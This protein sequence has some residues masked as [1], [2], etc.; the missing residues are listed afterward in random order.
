VRGTP[1]QDTTVGMSKA[2]LYQVS[3][4]GMFRRK[5]A[6]LQEKL[7]Y[8]LRESMD[9]LDWLSWFFVVAD[10]LIWPNP[11]V[12]NVLW[13]LSAWT[14]RSGEVKSCTVLQNNCTKE[15]N[16]YYVASS[17]LPLLSNSFMP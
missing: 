6:C 2:L 3:L 12:R 17:Y 11:C 13:R 4:S 16:I 8:H 10:S 5:H 9:N 14:Q 1:A 7:N 15:A